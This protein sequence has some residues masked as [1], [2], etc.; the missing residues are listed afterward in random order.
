MKTHPIVFLGVLSLLLLTTTQAATLFVDLSCANPTP[1]FSDWSTA[2]TN[3]QDAVDAAS[4]GDLVLVTNGLYNVGGRGV[5]SLTNRVLVTNTITLKSVNGPA[6]T[7]IE[8]HQ[9]PGTINDFGA[10][11]CVYLSAGA[12]LMGFTI[13]NGAT[14]PGDDDGIY[15]SYGGGIY[16]E[17]TS[18]LVTNCLIVNCS[19][20]DGGGGVYGGTVRNCVLTGNST[21][22][23]GYGYSSGGGA[24]A[25]TLINCGLSGNLAESG[26]GAYY[27]MLTNCTLTGNQAG[28]GGGASES[29]LNNCI[30]YFNTALTGPNIGD[31]WSTSVLNFCCTTPL[32][33]GGANNIALDPQ[34]A[35]PLH[36]SGVS[37][38]VSAGWWQTAPSYEHRM[39]SAECRP[40]RVH[41]PP[42][43]AVCSP[44]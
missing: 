10:V 38:C 12:T 4:S 31:V 26:G 16:C 27:C 21:T 44:R 36:I 33:A 32:P 7:V 22:V 13:T 15:E 43:Q 41:T 42:R 8:G 5:T 23:Y 14:E 3:I 39:A 35:D 24:T 34:L 25:A 30:V 37:P 6:V 17:G 11:R 20:G 9:I 18:S 28:N 2:A 1:P 29:V 40:R 19:A